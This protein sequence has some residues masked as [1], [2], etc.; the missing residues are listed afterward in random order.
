MSERAN[1]GAQRSAR[2]KRAVWRKRISERCEQTSERRSEWPSTLRVVS[3]VILPKLRCFCLLPSLVQRHNSAWR[4][5]SCLQKIPAIPSELFPAIFCFRLL[6]TH[7]FHVLYETIYIVRYIHVVYARR[8]IVQCGCRCCDT[9]PKTSPSYPQ[10][11]L[12]Q[13]GE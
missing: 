13:T 8:L 12:T 10:G 9:S 4:T 11:C 2:A 5:L 3:I 7:H 1:E 6:F